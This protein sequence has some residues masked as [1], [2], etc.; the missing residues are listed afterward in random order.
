MV[1][2]RLNRSLVFGPV[3]AMLLLVSLTWGCAGEAEDAPIDGVI[4]AGPK[5]SECP[6]ARCAVGALQCTAGGVQTC[7]TIDG[8]LGW[9]ATA[10]CPVDQ[11]CQRGVCAAGCVSQCAEGSTQCSGDAVQ[12]CV[13]LAPGC[14]AWGEAAACAAGETCS[15][16]ACAQGC[17]NECAEGVAVCEGDGIQRC[18]EGDADA[19]SDRLPV[20]NC[21][22]GESCSNG[23]CAPLAECQDECQADSRTCDGAAYTVCGQYD[24]DLCLEW[25]AA[26]A[27][28]AGLACSSGQC[29]GECEAECAP[30]LTRCAPDGNGYSECGQF[31]ADPCLDWGGAIACPGGETC[32]LGQCAVACQDECVAGSLRCGAGGPETC[33]AFDGDACLEWSVPTPCE[34]ETTCEAGACVAL[35]DC[36]HE[37]VGDARQ[38]APGGVQAC[39]LFDDDVCADWG[40]ATPCPEGQTCAS[41]ACQA[42]CADE[43]AVGSLRCGAQGGVETCGNFDLDPCAEWSDGV[44]CAE[45]QSCSAGV[46][47]MVC[48]DEC[49][50]AA[51][52]CGDGGVQRCGQHDPDDCLEWG[53]GTACPGVSVCALGQCVEHCQPE[54][55]EGSRRCQGDAV[56]QCGQFDADACPEWSTSTPCGAGELCSGGQCGAGCVPECGP[57]ALRCSADGV[58]ACAEVAGCARW[59]A[60]VGAGFQIGG[61]T[62]CPDTTTC[63]NGACAVV[64]AD[65]CVPGAARCGAGGREQC[66]HFDADACAEWSDAVACPLGEACSAGACAAECQ[67]ECDVGAARCTLD[68]ATGRAGTQR[69]GQ[70][71][72]DACREWGPETPCESNRCDAGVC[73]ACVPGPEVVDGLDNDCDG[74]I[75]EA[76]IGTL[77]DWCVLQ[78]PPRLV[79]TQGFATV[80]TYGQV[81][82]SGLTEAAGPHPGVWMQAGYGPRGALPDDGPGWTWAPQSFHNVQVGNNDEYLASLTVLVPGTF[83]YAWRASVDGGATWAYCD[84]DGNQAGLG[85]TAAQ[86]GALIVGPGVW[87]GNLQ[88]P[89]SMDVAAGEA[90]P[91]AYGRVYQQGVTDRNGPPAGLQAQFGYGPDASDPRSAE[92]WQWFDGRFNV[93]SGEDDEFCVG[94][95]CCAD[96]GA[97]DVPAPAAGFWDYGWRFSLDAGVS[98][99]YGD[100]DGSQNGYAPLNAGQLTVSAVVPVIALGWAGSWGM[101]FSR[102]ADC[103]SARE[104]IAE[105]VNIDS[106]IRERAACRQVIAELYAAGHTDA[107]GSDPRLIRAEVL[108][109]PVVGGV[110]G[111]P[112]T[113]PL[114]FYGRVGNNH[115]YRWDLGVGDFMAPA[116]REYRFFFRFSGDAGRTWYQIGQDEGP[117]AAAPRTML[118]TF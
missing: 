102:D 56:E 35:A 13:P 98:W 81:F 76:S 54:C 82:A 37:C 5:L 66:G 65:E 111:A 32:S 101:H 17:A 103:A 68:A 112:E 114:T 33:G 28:E 97:I 88:W 11:T 59:G 61:A 85:Y 70:F 96:C 84:L 86:A 7:E 6:M 15:A 62:P 75:D 3:W 113:L 52:R 26:I 53:L 47:A 27:C 107:D 4:D 77:P 49:V 78:H 100:T 8:C 79:T 10:A 23:L 90:L 9:G 40:P 72:S 29:V 39:G 110:E 2:P 92:G 106:W 31:D 57:G 30:G 71:D 21:A 34:G 115:E 74:R 18:G 20:E 12:T 67:D 58:Q 45:A 46:C 38:C 43:C 95:G 36:Q 48:Q 22:A 99:V 41:G 1:R 63:S 117:A 25:S 44:P 80:Q 51:L 64:C 87:W 116:A 55:A 14:A 19:C 42:E 91:S 109:R 16:G 94:A 118:Y 104:A 24:E 89:H 93:D 105:P 108:R 69:C 60:I 83:D 50:L 73:V